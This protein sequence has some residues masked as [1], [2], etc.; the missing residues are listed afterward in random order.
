MTKS[1]LEGEEL[2]NSLFGSETRS[3]IL[4][5]LLSSDQDSFRLSDIAKQTEMDISGVSREILNLSSLG[6][7]EN[8]EEGKNQEYKINKNHAFFNGLREIF[9][10]TEGLSKKYFLWEEMPACYPSAACDFMNVDI[11]NKFLKENSLKARLTKTLSIYQY[12]NLKIYFISEEYRGISKETLEI[13]LENPKFGLDDVNNALKVSEKFLKFCDTIEEQ[14]FT[15]LSNQE[16]PRLLKFYQA[17]YEKLHIRG[18]IANATDAPDMLF[19]KHLILLLKEKIKK[20]GSLLNAQNAFSKLTTPVEESFMQKEHEDM[21]KIL[22]EIYSDKHLKE[23]FMN[24]EPRH[25]LSKVRNTSIGRK[26]EKHTHDFGWVGYNII[27]PNW[28]ELYFIGIISSLAKQDKDPE[29]MLEEIKQKKENLIKEQE[30]ITKTLELNEKEK[31]LFEVARGFVFSKGYRKDAMFKFFSR[32]ELFYRE[33]S[34]RMHVSVTDIRF[35]FPHEFDEFMSQDPKFIQKLTE[36]QK[37]GIVESVGNYSEDIYLNGDKARE[38]L[39]KLPFEKEDISQVS[40]LDGTCACPGRVRGRVRMIN[41]P[42]EMDNMEKGDILVSIATSPDLVT[43]MK[44][45]GAIVTDMGGITSHA[46]IV[47]RELNI[48]CVVGTKIATRVL[49]QDMLVDVDATHGTVRILEK[50]KN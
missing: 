42:K 36:R 6:I 43:A 30:R 28:D 27:G 14:N 2:L 12:P 18:W 20:K 4:K 44:K 13:L 31:Q 33:I 26:I 22:V 46:A 32:I 1:Q 24:F 38:H 8:V 34:R 35:C 29:K 50:T 7:I 40:L 47:S 10:K 37:F 45:A 5:I 15:S 9:Q 39:K 41:T 19:T 25:I 11:T 49:K 3:K 48:P 17:E 23:I 21:L 16:L